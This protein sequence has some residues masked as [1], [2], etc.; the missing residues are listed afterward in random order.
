MG[1]RVYELRMKKVSLLNQ[2][3]EIDKEIFNIQDA[4][5]KKIEEQYGISR[6]DK[7]KKCKGCFNEC[8]I[9]CAQCSFGICEQ[10]KYGYKNIVERLRV[11]Y[12]VDEL[13]NL[14]RR[15]PYAVLASI[16]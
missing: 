12:S 7:D 3:S 5:K 15:C 6:L 11:K 2:I 8:I 9:P 14:S 16:K 1:D 4:D 10:C 13:E